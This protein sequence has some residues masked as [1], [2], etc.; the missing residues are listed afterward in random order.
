MLRPAQREAVRRIRAAFRDAGGAL[1][2]DPPGTGKT[3]VA[4]AVA[5]ETATGGMTIVVAPAALRDQWHRAAC[6]AAVGMHFVSMEQLSRRAV[7]GGDARLVIVDE[8]H[9]AR[10]RGTQ[11]HRRLAEL[12]AGRR[13]L[14]LSAT[15]V[16][17]REAEL[18]ALL[19]LFLGEHATLGTALSARTACVIRRASEA[20]HTP[21][22]TRLPELV[23]PSPGA[24]EIAARL[25][26]LPPPLPAA[27]GR[28]ALAL[29][30]LTL[31]MAWSSSLAALDAALRRR[32]HR[33][34]A[35]GDGLRA[36]LLPSR[37]DL[38]HWLI[39]DDATQ[40]ALPA[41]LGDPS[42]AS[43]G[44]D[45][46]ALLTAHLEAVRAL[47]ALV[48]PD[49][50][51]DSARRADA[52][53]G[54]LRTRPAGRAVVFSRHAE[55]VRALWRALRG[56]PGVVAIVGDRVLAAAGRWRRAEV[57]AAVGPQARPPRTDDPRAIRL[58][59][60]TDLLAEGVELTGIDTLVH[61]DRAWTPA[62][63]EQREGRIAR[64][65]KRG[66]VVTSFA[67]PREAE[68]LLRLAH[69]LARKER[70]RRRS[71]RAADCLSAA[72]ISFEALRAPPV[73][74]V[75][76][77]GPATAFLAALH[78]RGN[79]GD[80]TEIV[81]G[82]LRGERWDVSASPCD[83][84]RLARAACDGASGTAGPAG[85]LAVRTALARWMRRARTR[86]ILGTVAP[87][88][89]VR[90]DAWR[91]LATRIDQAL[92][93]TPFGERLARAASI[94]RAVRALR[95][96]GS[97]GVQRRVIAMLEEQRSSTPASFERALATLAATC[98]ARRAAPAREARVV[99]PCLRALLW[100][101]PSTAPRAARRRH[102]RPSASPGSAAPR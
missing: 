89:G 90:A 16:V 47:R 52:V 55:T 37:A 50:H 14:L 63:M 98:Q 65:A 3:I 85:L 34:E 43:P 41:L 84:A 22:I 17:N 59:L 53:E 95:E 61:A 100:L 19:G 60:T 48:T 101:S 82:R 83:I 28:A 79:A 36:G 81:A 86:V 73:Q 87:S 88:P 24:D 15:P 54:L 18:S 45:A 71:T 40:L 26:R 97:V 9:H 23:V 92:R 91:R 56:R 6:R 57:L 38:R 62:T 93:A 80:G 76:T 11:R 25:G 67:P 33:G 77:T 94:D 74:R 4:L 78:W 49:V 7:D 69:R 12:C 68:S 64:G 46:L 72:D 35:L 44:D 30:R 32:I 39:G 29:V 1:L 99:R 31:A 5:R 42:T 10:S 75:P 13:V 102:A 96:V 21:A 20:R 51:A 70:S 27:D 58:L 66:V 2:A 8:A